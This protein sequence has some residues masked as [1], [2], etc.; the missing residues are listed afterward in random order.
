MQAIIIAGGKGTRIRSLIKTTPK[1]LLPLKDQLLVDH[2]MQHLKKN[3]ITD[4]VIS[5]GYLGDKVQQYIKE[6][7]YEITV[8]MFQEPKPVGTS[9]ALSLMKDLLDDE[10]F[11]LYGDVYTTVNLKNMFLFHKSNNADVT[12]AL[13]TSDHPQDST[14]VKIDNKNRINAMIEKPGSDWEKFGNLTITPIFFVK[15]E[16]L[17][18]IKPK[19]KVDLT[20]DTLPA[21]FKNGKKLFGYVTNEY[22]KDIGTPE[23]Y[24]EVL[25]LLKS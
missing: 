22:A 8:K 4:V 11:I 14:I 7:K 20:K 13:H 5:L 10:F 6:K 23:R 2:L 16:I 9:G 3:G 12:I 25:S 1:L 19:Y 17:N 15:K 21:L 24:N 18:F